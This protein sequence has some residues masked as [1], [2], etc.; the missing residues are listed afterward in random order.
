MSEMPDVNDIEWDADAWFID[1]EYCIKCEHRF[2]AHG[3][4]CPMLADWERPIHAE[5][6]R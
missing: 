1:P 5:G 4:K 6:E 2:P 3:S